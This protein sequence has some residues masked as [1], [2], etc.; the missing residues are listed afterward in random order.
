[1]F[2][3]YMYY[4]KDVI[5]KVVFLV[6]V[7]NNKILKFKFGKYCY[8]LLKNKKFEIFFVGGGGYKNNVL[9]VCKFK[10]RGVYLK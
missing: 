3:F 7:G 9:Y 4:C 10:K 8:I 5:C 2:L 1:M 6:L